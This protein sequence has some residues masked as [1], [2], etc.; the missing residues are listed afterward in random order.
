MAVGRRRRVAMA[1]NIAPDFRS[2]DVS[3]PV[4]HPSPPD[5]RDGRRGFSS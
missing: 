1:H 3:L 5:V 2:R 4:L